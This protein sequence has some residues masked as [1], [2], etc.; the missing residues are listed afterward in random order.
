MASLSF[1]VILK[2]NQCAY[3]WSRAG[4]W[5]EQPLALVLLLKC[6][7]NWSELHH[8]ASPSVADCFPW[9][10]TAELC[11]LSHHKTQCSPLISDKVVWVL[12]RLPKESQY[13]STCK[14]STHE[15]RIVVQRKSEGIFIKSSPD[16]DSA[17]YSWLVDCF[18]SKTQGEL[19]PE[20]TV[21]VYKP[22]NY[23]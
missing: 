1:C 13:S 9:H 11:P 18:S 17:R 7:G 14:M 4:R 19:C 6:L 15:Y 23:Q 22:W 21:A 3:G 10:C 2:A 20:I 16:D 5:K 8:P 12:N